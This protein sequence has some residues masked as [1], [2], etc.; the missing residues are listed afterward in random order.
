MNEKS[1][2]RV[3]RKTM[4]RGACAVAGAVGL[5]AFGSIFASCSND[6]L[7]NSIDTDIYINSGKSAKA[8]P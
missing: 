4:K 5:A 6:S 2:N 3:G 1:M 8:D 7:S